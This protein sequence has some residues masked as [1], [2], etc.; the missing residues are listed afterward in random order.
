[1]SPGIRRNKLS[2]AKLQSLGVN[3]DICYEC[4]QPMRMR[5]EQIYDV[6]SHYLFFNSHNNIYKIFHRKCKLKYIRRKIRRNK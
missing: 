2:V 3:T 4:K 6:P 1:M 5:Y